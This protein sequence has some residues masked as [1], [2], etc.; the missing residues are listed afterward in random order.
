MDIGKFFSFHGR[1]GRGAFWGLSFL[2]SLIGFGGSAALGYFDSTFSEGSMTYTLL[3]IL[4][5]VLIP[6]G[7]VIQLATSVKRWHDR[8][9]SGWWILISFIPIIGALWSLIEQGILAGTDDYNE[10][11]T[12]GSG[13]PFGSGSQAVRTDTLARMRA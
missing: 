13:S 2:G 5:L 10:Y 1:I 9:K 6:V 3:A 8:G 4:A 12:P 11:G 7:V